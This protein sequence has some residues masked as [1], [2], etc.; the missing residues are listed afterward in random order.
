MSR[1]AVLGYHKVGPPAP[2][3]WDTWYYV[4]ERVFADQLAAVRECGWEPIDV[5]ALLGALAGSRPL[6]E[7]AALVTFDDGYRS[8]R[9][10]AL[11]VLQRHACPA[12]L[13]VP[14]GFVGRTNEFDR[15]AEPEEPISDWPELSELARAGV[16]IQS[17]GVSHTTFSALSGAGRRE[18]LAAS[19]AEL[20]RRLGEPVD[21]FAYPY[22][23]DAEGNADVRAALVES[24]YRAAFGYGGDPFQLPA[25][26]P[27]RLARVAMGPDTDLRALLRAAA[28]AR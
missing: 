13:F 23:D 5:A 12:V 10:F 8:V 14:T 19:K 15:G 18:E 11:P 25:G 28:E 17:H 2:G 6:P 4:P 24:G 1:L 22:G 16:S 26:D 20:E 7:R 3:G 9:E 21:L 27:Y